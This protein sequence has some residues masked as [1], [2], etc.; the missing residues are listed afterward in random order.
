MGPKENALSSISKKL[1]CI[2]AWC[3]LALTLPMSAQQ[4]DSDLTLGLVEQ[5]LSAL[6]AEGAEDND[7]RTIAYTQVQSFVERAETQD[8]EADAY[9]NALTSAPVREGDIQGRIDELA[10][11][12]DPRADLAGITTEEVTI[13]LASRETESINARN[14]LADIDVRINKLTTTIAPI[15][16]SANPSLAEARLWQQ[17]AEARALSAEI[18]ALKGAQSSQAV[19]FSAMSA[20]QAE[21]VL[22]N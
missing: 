21:L 19:R 5:R 18:R 15:E 4:T 1:F 3:W 8:R 14:R 13:R 11:S 2:T 20:E 6:R 17:L 16:L 22:I 7:E 12:D 9:V 10:D